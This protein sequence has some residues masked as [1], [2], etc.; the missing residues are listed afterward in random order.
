[1]FTGTRGSALRDTDK[2]CDV[3]KW[4]FED[5]AAVPKINTNCTGGAKAA[6]LGGVRDSSGTIEV[7]LS[8]DGTMQMR[9]GSS[10]LLRLLADTDDPNDYIEVT[11]VI[12]STPFEVD[13]DS[14]DNVIGTTYN[15][16]GSGVVTYSGIFAEGDTVC[17][18]SGA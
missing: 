4:T 13:L 2:I 14:D 16:Q 1:M 5:T 3:H 11:G 10:Y 15:F 8:K 7:K 6:I 18:S 12:E 17:C 9:P